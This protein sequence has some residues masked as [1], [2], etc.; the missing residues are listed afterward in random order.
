M[1]PTAKQGIVGLTADA[2]Q[3]PKMQAAEGRRRRG[4]D[5]GFADGQRITV[6]DTLHTCGTFQGDL[7]PLWVTVRPAGLLY[8]QNEMTD[9]RNSIAHAYA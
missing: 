9:H 8:V 3:L 7:S 5:N 6:C 2:A 4:P 1:T